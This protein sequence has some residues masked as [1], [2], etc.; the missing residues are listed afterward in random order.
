MEELAREMQ[1]ALQE[2]GEAITTPDEFNMRVQEVV[3]RTGVHPRAA[4]NPSHAF[5]RPVA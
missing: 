1:S 2:G 3:G 5:T 4:S